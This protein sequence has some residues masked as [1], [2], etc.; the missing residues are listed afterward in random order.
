MCYVVSNNAFVIST[1][2][3]WVGTYLPTCYCSRNNFTYACHSLIT[4]ILHPQAT[5]HSQKHPTLPS[6]A[7][8]Y[9]ASFIISYYIIYTYYMV[10]SIVCVF[11]R[12]LYLVPYTHT[13]PV[14]LHGFDILTLPIGT[15]A[16]IIQCR[17]FSL[18]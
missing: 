17:Y 8:L 16:A 7:V 4:S 5:S 9:F 6:H 1:N 15:A 14:L 18:C 2:T 11:L 12:T 3:H 13:T 10:L